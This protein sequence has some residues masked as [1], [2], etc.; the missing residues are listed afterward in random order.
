MQDRRSVI[1]DGSHNPMKIER[2]VQFLKKDVIA[3]REAPGRSHANTLGGDREIASPH[4]AR[5]DEENSLVHCVFASCAN[6]DAR[7]MIWLLEPY[8]T[9]WY[10]TQFTVGRRAFLPEALAAF[11]TKPATIYTDPHAALAS[12]RANAGDRGAIVITG[13]FFLAGELR[14]EWISEEDILAARSSF[15]R[16]AARVEAPSMIAEPTSLG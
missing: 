11:A 8:V 13:S 10:F 1:I 15:P 2:L 4:R 6:K 3:R 7:T 5:N 16:I 9:Q 14:R 12:A